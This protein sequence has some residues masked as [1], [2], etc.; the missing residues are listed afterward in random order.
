MITFNAAVVLLNLLIFYFFG[1][2][3]MKIQICYATYVVMMIEAGNYIE[4]YG[5]VRKQ[6]AQGIYEAVNLEALLDYIEHY[7]LVRKQD[8]QGI[9]E[10]V[11]LRH[12]W[13]APQVF[14]N[15]CLFKL[16]RHSDHHLNVYKPYQ[17][18]DSFEESPLLPYGYGAAITLAH[19]PPI[20]YKIANPQAEATNKN[21][22]LTEKT[23]QELQVYI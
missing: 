22:K 11:N 7:G 4:H 17:I 13:N 12:S 15:Y 10:A 9:Y 8:A 21:V 6:D 19:F 16:Q 5:L 1:W 20:W 2:Y 23:M 14:S 18:L 3:G